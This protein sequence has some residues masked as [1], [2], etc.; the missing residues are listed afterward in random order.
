M[1]APRV[2]A[3]PAPSSSP[4]LSLTDLLLFV[5]QHRFLI[6]GLPILL[7]VLAYLGSLL[8]A[9]SYRATSTIA[10]SAGT[11]AFVLKRVADSDLVR[12]RIFA[13]LNFAERHGAQSEP[14]AAL[15][16]SRS[17]ATNASRDGMLSISA[18]DRE[19]GYA[20]KLADRIA[21][22]T[23]GTAHD[24]RL[25]ASA[26]TLQKLRAHAQQLGSEAEELEAGLAKVGITNWRNVLSPNEA[27]VIQVVADLQA[28]SNLRSGT[29]AGPNE[30][31][32]LF[33]L[34]Q[35]RLAGLQGQ[36]VGKRVGE[37]GAV[38]TPA[39]FEVL[40]ELYY[41]SALRKRIAR[42]IEA[43][44]R[45]QVEEIRLAA[46]AAVPLRPQHPRPVF[47]AALGAA[48]GLAIAL[49]VALTRE[50]R[51]KSAAQLGLVDEPAAVPAAPRARSAN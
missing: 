16:Y 6:L 41:A 48:L 15:I 36:L 11:P 46:P 28:E 10:P 31:T 21:Q 33:N 49:I 2:R 23:I 50:R 42:Q 12:S 45:E 35:D 30:S 43:A 1:T 29:P 44:E 19:P 5:W 34:V 32:L 39:A 4:D 18:D 47:N 24:Q 8:L 13:E 26:K 25:S 17:I 51:R 20:A 27:A 38:L 14:E 3:T 9:P 37:S 40:K 22:L 7:A